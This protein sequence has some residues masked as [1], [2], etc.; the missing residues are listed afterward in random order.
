MPQNHILRQI[1][2]VLDFS[3]I[4]EW[5]AP[6]D[7][8]RTGRPAVGPELVMRIIGLAY[9]FNPSERDL[10]QTLPMH[11]WTTGRIYLNMDEDEAWKKA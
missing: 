6:L 8:E 4:H 10:F 3:A 5:A 1:D 7:S 9:L 11:E 2:R